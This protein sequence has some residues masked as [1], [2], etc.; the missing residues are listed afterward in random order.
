MDIKTVVI[1]TIIVIAVAYIVYRLSHKGTSGQSKSGST[2]S[3][4]A[5]GQQHA[6]PDN[7]H[8]E[9]LRN[10]GELRIGLVELANKL[11]VDGVPEAVRTRVNDS[12]SVLLGT[13][14]QLEKKPHTDLAAFVLR[15][16]SK[17]YPDILTRFSSLS[18]EQ[19]QEKQAELFARLDDLDSELRDTSSQLDS[20]AD[21]D[22]TAKARFLQAKFPPDMSL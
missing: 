7:R 1:V 17:F 3:P 20:R 6:A 16:G 8:S 4:Q 9:M 22:F 18:P 21:F 14:E 19:M 11:Y 12:F 5:S 10:F 15:I 2:P 13:L